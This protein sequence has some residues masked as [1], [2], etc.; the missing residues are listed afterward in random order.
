MNV[1]YNVIILES[2]I[3]FYILYDCMTVIVTCDRYVTVACDIILIT[4]T[5]SPK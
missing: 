2:F 5:L 4:L 3:F 1:L